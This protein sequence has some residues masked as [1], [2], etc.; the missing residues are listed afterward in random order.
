[1]PALRQRPGANVADH[2]R[3]TGKRIIPRRAS[4][5]PQ[6]S[7][8]TARLVVRVLVFETMSRWILQD[9]ASSMPPPSVYMVSKTTIIMYVN[10]CHIGDYNYFNNRYLHMPTVCRQLERTVCTSFKV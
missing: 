4:L 9:K 8:R 1:M 10:N 3:R 7:V 5:L 6:F 2:L